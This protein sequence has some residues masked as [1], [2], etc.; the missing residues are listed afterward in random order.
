MLL[1]LPLQPLKD[2]K[3][4]CSLWHQEVD[5]IMKR[6]K[7][8]KM[9]KDDYLEVDKVLGGAKYSSNILSQLH[10]KECCTSNDKFEKLLIFKGT[11]LNQLTLERCHLNVNSFM[12][13]VLTDGFPYLSI[14]TLRQNEYV[15]IKGR[16]TIFIPKDGEEELKFK[17]LKV[18]E[19][20]ERGTETQ[21]SLHAIAEM[22]PSLQK[23]THSNC[24]I[25]ARNRN[26]SVNLSCLN[27]LQLAPI[28][29]R[30]MEFQYFDT[31]VDLKLKRLKTLFLYGM[32]PGGKKRTNSLHKFL[33]SVSSSVVSLHLGQK[34]LYNPE[35]QSNAPSPFPIS[36]NNLKRISIGPGFIH[37]LKFLDK[38][39]CVTSFTCTRQDSKDWET[40]VNKGVPKSTT[41]VGSLDLGTITAGP[42]LKIAGA[43]PSLCRLEL[44]VSRIQNHDE[45]FRTICGGFSQLQILNIYDISNQNILTD[46]GV[47][48]IASL[49]LEALKNSTGTKGKPKREFSYIGDLKCK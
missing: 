29:G 27:F 40:I 43:F 7:T 48:G 19:I 20:D 8:I 41:I 4:V 13:M 39:P 22:C 12:Y 2:C 25:P 44:N 3:A 5:R 17:S 49:E 33:K 38:L 23:L 10:C 34:I 30:K 42:L 32:T 9:I 15:D 47:T 28:D 16:K 11:F 14:L 37:S 24:P 26:S 46:T 36:M 1:S 18:L 31:L 6:L 45:L 21:T 35:Y